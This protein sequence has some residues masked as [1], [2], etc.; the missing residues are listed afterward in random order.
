MDMLNVASTGMYTILELFVNFKEPVELAYFK[1]STNSHD[2]R[3]LSSS[4]LSSLFT[5]TDLAHRRHLVIEPAVA[6]A[7]L[8][9]R[10]NK[11]FF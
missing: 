3:S 4:L 6:A 8:H 10:S 2:D 7:S 11:L 9:Q 5:D 1:T